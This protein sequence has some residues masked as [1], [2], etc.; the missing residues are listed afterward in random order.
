MSVY[1]YVCLKVKLCVHFVLT[2]VHTWVTSMVTTDLGHAGVLVMRGRKAGRQVSES[3][4]FVPCTVP[5][6][7]VG[8]SQGE[9]VRVERREKER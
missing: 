8:E 7:G 2:Y 5:P 9:V 3:C 6:R 1:A 4:L